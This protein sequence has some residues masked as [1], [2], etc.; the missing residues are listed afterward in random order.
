VRQ[1]G[2]AE[3]GGKH[4]AGKLA[5]TGAALHAEAQELQGVRAQLRSSGTLVHMS[6]DPLLGPLFAC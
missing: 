1:G 6:Q 2:G 5:D 4:G 3:C